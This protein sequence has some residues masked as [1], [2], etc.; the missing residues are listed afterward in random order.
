VTLR[1]ATYNIH[2]FVGTDGKWDD[3]RILN[4]VRALDADLV[5]LQEF[6][7]RENATVA[8]SPES[9][10]SAAGYEVIAQPLL[11][12]NGMMQFNVLM[13]RL[14]LRSRT[15]LE[16]PRD[17]REPRGAIL[18]EMEAHGRV[19]RLAA[20]H[21]GLTP[22]A[23]KRQL[24]Q[25]LDAAGVDSN[26]PFVL[27]GDL[28]ITFPWE[29]ARARLRSAFPGQRQ[30][31]AFPSQWPFLSVDGIY[32]RPRGMLRSI[33]AVDEDTTRRASDHLPLIAEMAFD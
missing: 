14:L 17:G 27:M 20:T 26:Y 21:F 33:R 32:V 22:N 18:A 3:E 1:L 8:A 7:G 25:V 15:L 16:L 31:R 4:I 2:K 11:R 28:N 5:A 24:A 9:F 6:V 12:P 29:V 23:R 13:S 30:P 19:L 10:A